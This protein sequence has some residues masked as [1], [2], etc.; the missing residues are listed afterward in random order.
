M[1]QSAVN[2]YQSCLQRPPFVQIREC[3]LRAARAPTRVQ[4]R[5]TWLGAEHTD[6]DLIAAPRAKPSETV[7]RDEFLAA[8]RV[9][10]LLLADATRFDTQPRPTLFGRFVGRAVL[11][12]IAFH[13]FAPPRHFVAEQ[14]GPGSNRRLIR[15][16]QSGL[17]R[18]KGAAIVKGTAAIRGIAV[19]RCNASARSSLD[20]ARRRPGG[21]QWHRHSANS[22][23]PHQTW[24]RHGVGR[25]PRNDRT[26][27]GRRARCFFVHQPQH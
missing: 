25:G 12:K 6:D 16:R 22:F 24:R 19:V 4:F 9:I 20:A 7:E 11:L 26:Q 2:E 21:V 27:Q 17:G 15:R 8:H 13:G 3:P 14:C 10:P 1:L 23:A 18:S 5:P